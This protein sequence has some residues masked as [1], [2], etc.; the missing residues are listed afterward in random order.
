MNAYELRPHFSVCIATHERPSLLRKTMEA[1]MNQTRLPDEIVVSDSSHT[2]ATQELVLD[3]ASWDSAPLI[4]YIHSNS[5]VLP[6]QRWWAFTHAR[7][8][9]ILFLDDDV[10]LSTEALSVLEINYSKNTTECIAGIG[11]V[12]TLPGHKVNVRSLDSFE[13]RWLNTFQIPSAFIQPGGTTTPPK[14]P[15]LEQTI[16]VGRLW[17]GAM[18]YPRGILQQIGPLTELFRLY[19]GR[20]GRGED[21][22]LSYYASQFGQLFLITKPLAVHPE[23]EQAVHNA[24]STAGWRKG[25]T[26]TWGKA[27]TQRWLARDQKAFWNEWARAASLEVLRSLWWGVFRQPFRRQGWARLLGAL[28]GCILTITRYHSIP[29]SA[30]LD[31][32]NHSCVQST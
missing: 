6:W 9:I 12:K 4:I 8:D 5:S 14:F 17:G 3:F 20:I 32:V 21:A 23:D 15:L 25:L 29:L 18:S 19:E 26:E 2:Q 16:P 11:F 22:V 28:W 10:Q 27:H 31:K 24:Y 13:E 1:L 7:G 30:G